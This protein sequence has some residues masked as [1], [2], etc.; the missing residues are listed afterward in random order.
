[1]VWPALRFHDPSRT[2]LSSL[3]WAQL[4]G[5]GALPPAPTPAG[6]RPRPPSLPTRSVQSLLGH[7]F[8]Q[9]VIKTQTEYQLS[10]ADQPKKFS[11]L[12]AQKLSG[13]PLEDGRS[14]VTRLSVPGDSGPGGGAAA[15]RCRTQALSFAPTSL[16]SRTCPPDAHRADDCVHHGAPGLRADHVQGHLV[17]PVQ[18][19]RRLPASGKAIDPCLRLERAVKPCRRRPSKGPT[20]GGGPV[21]GGVPPPH[22]RGDGVSPAL[23]DMAC[24]GP[25]ARHLP[26]TLESYIFR[27]IKIRGV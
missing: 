21:G 2:P 22:P 19:P 10:S 6:S 7:L 4:V 25:S 27:K 3:P 13:N 18:L 17:R 23:G 5:T 12:E 8:P 20:G 16:S 26:G 9:V 24:K 1:M 15:A 14:R 11:D